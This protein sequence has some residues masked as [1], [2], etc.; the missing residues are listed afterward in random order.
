[1]NHDTASQHG[2]NKFQ[3][4]VEE[5]IHT[6]IIGDVSLQTA[7][8]QNETTETHCL[9]D[10]PSENRYGN[11]SI[12]SHTILPNPSPSLTCAPVSSDHEPEGSQNKDTTLREKA[13]NKTTNHRTPSTDRMEDT[14]ETGNTYIANDSSIL[15]NGAAIAEPVDEKEITD[16]INRRVSEELKR[17][18]STATAVERVNDKTLRNIFRERK[19]FFV[20]LTLSILLVIA[21]VS[22]V[23]I[24]LSVKKDET[25]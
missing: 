12:E 8:D 21:I 19:Q 2:K 14:A 11:G 7:T 17:C 23:P 20:L 16:E 9:V 25:T 24:I 1:M 4:D 6:S 5:N 15:Y 3:N 18:Q 22:L 13:S 10:Q